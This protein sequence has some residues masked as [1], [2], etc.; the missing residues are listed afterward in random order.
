MNLGPTRKQQRTV[1]MKNE[2]RIG[3]LKVTCIVEV[4]ITKNDYGALTLQ[5]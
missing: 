5:C 1:E 4:G 2:H 3:L